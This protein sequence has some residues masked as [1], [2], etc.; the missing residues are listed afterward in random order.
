MRGRRLLLAVLI[1]A[2]LAVGVTVV[3]STA[4]ARRG[5]LTPAERKALR[6][7][8]VKAV[9]EEPTGLVV[10]ATFAGDIEHALGRGNLQ[11][12][13]VAMVLLPKQAPFVSAGLVTRGAGRVGQTLRSTHSTQVGVLR[14]GRKL[15][16]FIHGPG[17][18]QVRAVAVKAFAREPGTSAYRITQAALDGAPSLLSQDRWKQ[19]ENQ[20]ATDQKQVAVAASGLSAAGCDDLDDL[21][22]ELGEIVKRAVSTR[23][24]LESY[25]IELENAIDALE[26]ERSLPPR[27]L[28]DLFEAADFV[29]AD[30]RPRATD[31]AA[32]L[33][34]LNSMEAALKQTRARNAFLIETAVSTRTA[35]QAELKKCSSL[36]TPSAP[37]EV[38]LA[39][40]YDHTTSG[41]PGFP[42]T[43]CADFTTHPPQPSA[44]WQ[45]TLTWPDGVKRAQGSFGPDQ[46]GRVVFGI[47]HGDTTYQLEIEVTNAAGHTEAASTLILV[48][49]PPPSNKTK[50]C[51][52]PPAPA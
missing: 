43:V 46:N 25:G 32:E 28:E 47:P 33:R 37:F 9:G 22:D 7:V 8:S 13:A 42:S 29:G 41:G 48:P 18:S 6:I 12:A 5:A 30:E 50:D 36:T 16:F 2:G 17:A 35:A 44:G 3:G 52:A 40:G 38:E 15:I 23:E 10:T 26:H 1:A 34:W 4:N 20:I 24:Q 39:A 27:K 45:A 11:H 21:V 19:Y 31:R 49:A 51:S 14:E